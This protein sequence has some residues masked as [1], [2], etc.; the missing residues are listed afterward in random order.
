M[1]V[2]RF[3]QSPIVTVS[4]LDCLKCFMAIILLTAEIYLLADVESLMEA[5]Q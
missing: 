3:L 2:I 5:V 4:Y 1:K